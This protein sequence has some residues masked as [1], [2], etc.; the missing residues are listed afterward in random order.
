M[1]PDDAMRTCLRSGGPRTG[2]DDPHYCSDE[3]SK[4]MW[5]PHERG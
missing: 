5:S 1:T 2:G 4:L 3:V